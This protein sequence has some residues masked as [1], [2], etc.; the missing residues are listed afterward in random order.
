[1]ANAAQVRAFDEQ[2]RKSVVEAQRGFQEKFNKLIDALQNFSRMER[3]SR[4]AG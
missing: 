2:Q 3:A 1:V 4:K